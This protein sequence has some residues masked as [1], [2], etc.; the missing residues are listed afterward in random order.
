MKIGVTFG[1]CSLR[2]SNGTGSKAGSRSPGGSTGFESGHFYGVKSG[3]SFHPALLYETAKNANYKYKKGGAA[4]M[5]PLAPF[6][7]L[8]DGLASQNLSTEMRS[9]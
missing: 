1:R 4:L 9:R 8:I 3:S 7:G 2:S 5:N 6:D